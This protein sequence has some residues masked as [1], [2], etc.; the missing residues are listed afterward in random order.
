[1]GC[2]HT[3]RKGSA[4]IFLQLTRPDGTHLERLKVEVDLLLL[5]LVGEDGTAVD[6][7]S[8]GWDLVVELET[9]LGRGDGGQNRE[10]VDARLDVGSCRR[11]LGSATEPLPPLQTGCSLTAI[12][13][14]YPFHTPGSACW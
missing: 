8:V 5:A 12:A 6:D 1:M 14:T 9:L 11:K 13:P 3:I 7:E 10:T 4:L 2:S